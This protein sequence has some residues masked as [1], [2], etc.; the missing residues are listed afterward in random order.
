MA[1]EFFQLVDR[2]GRPAGRATREEC[3]GNPLLI[4]LVVHLHVLDSEDRLLLQKRAMTKDTNPGRWDTSVGGHVRAGEDVLDA[5]RRE[6]REELGIDAAGAVF[7]YG[8]LY[9]S[10][11]E[12]EFAQCFLLRHSGTVTADPVEIDEVRFFTLREVTTMVGTG[13]LTPMFEHELPMLM[14]R[15][16]RLR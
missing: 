11:F 15:P 7:L 1:V 9:G 16:E 8:Y 5:L 6:A 13:S 10:A 4:H 2:E 14:Q 12:T 3:H